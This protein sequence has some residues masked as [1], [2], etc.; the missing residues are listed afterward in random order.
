[1][2]IGMVA[3]SHEDARR[4]IAMLKPSDDFEGDLLDTLR[5][6]AATL[7]QGGSVQTKV[8]CSGEPLELSPA[9]KQTLLRIGHEAI[10]NAVRH[11]APSLIEL[12]L[13]FEATAVRLCVRDDGCGFDTHARSTRGF[14]LLGMRSR[15]ASQGGTLH[16]QSRP[17]H[18]CSLEVA[19]PIQKRYSAWRSVAV[20]RRLKS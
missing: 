18:G 19:V 14:G 4:T 12:R 2:A 8:E 1:M 3:H 20:L 17:H 6:Q 9:V 11:A 7:T 5:Q 15:A 16:I 13:F 10:T